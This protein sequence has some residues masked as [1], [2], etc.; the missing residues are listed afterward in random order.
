MS[1]RKLARGLE[2]CPLCGWVL[3][4]AKRKKPHEG[5]PECVVR[6]TQTT[7]RLRGWAQCANKVEAA[8]LIECGAEVERAPA[9][10]TFVSVYT[11]T[12]PGEE[13][14]R[15]WGDA[16][17]E[18]DESRPHAIVEV[19]EHR[20]FAHRR[21]LDAVRIVSSGRLEKPVRRTALKRLLE[22]GS[23]LEAAEAVVALDTHG[24]YGASVRQFL[25]H[26]A[27][28]ERAA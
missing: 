26:L 19:A 20:Y 5:T 24:R 3:R 4:P 8:L 11:D 7:Y 22:D 25:R 15:V 17:A 18:I 13:P 2:A 1:K 10:V 12:L 14:E 28:A 9:M 23:V 6:A 16:D 27:K 21:T